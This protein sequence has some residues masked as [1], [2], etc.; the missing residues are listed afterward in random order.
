MTR[1]NVHIT[2]PEAE[3]AAAV[4]RD[5]SGRRLEKETPQKNIAIK[6]TPEILK[7][8]RAP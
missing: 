4:F 1:L 3:A 8:D 5:T 7:S 6:L 2:S